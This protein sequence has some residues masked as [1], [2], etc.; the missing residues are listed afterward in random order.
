MRREL[1]ID[2]D[3]VAHLRHEI[4][5]AIAE[6]AALPAEKRQIALAEAGL[7]G[8]ALAAAVTAGTL[9]PPSSC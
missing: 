5:A 8:L 6:V 1:H 2:L 4:A 9:R 7:L 3:S